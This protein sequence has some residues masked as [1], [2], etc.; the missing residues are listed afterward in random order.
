[1][2]DCFAALA[3]LQHSDRDRVARLLDTI[4]EGQMQDL[5]LFPGED[6]DK[7]EALATRGDLDRYT[8][9]VAGCVGEFWTDVHM[10]HRPRLAGWDR[11]R[12]CAFGV[13]FGQG[14]QLTNVLRDVPR[15]LRRGRCYLPRQELARL[16]LSPRD[17]LDPG[18]TD[19]ARPLLALLVSQALE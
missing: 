2:P 16:G 14:L 13:R 19:A 7:L 8:Y 9:L 1:L 18:A 11:A 5:V 6:E 4:V 17:L 10:A 15:D 3:G 12:M